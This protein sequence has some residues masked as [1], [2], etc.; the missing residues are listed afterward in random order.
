MFT[1]P[2]NSIQQQANN[3]SNYVE[4]IA[5]AF[6]PPPLPISAPPPAEESL[7]TESICQD[8][9]GAAGSTCVDL[10]NGDTLPH[11][12]DVKDIESFH[13]CEFVL[14][15]KSQSFEECATDVSVR[16]D[17]SCSYLDKSEKLL[18]IDV[19]SPA[20]CPLTE[21]D[22]N[23]PKKEASLPPVI[24]RSMIE[25]A[26]LVDDGEKL[27]TDVSTRYSSVAGRASS[28]NSILD[29]FDARHTQSALAGRLKGLNIPSC[30]AAMKR[31]SSTNSI[32]DD[33]F[34]K[35]GS[36]L[37]AS[38]PRRAPMNSNIDMTD[39]NSTKRPATSIFS[40]KICIDSKPE[41][42]SV[43][44]SIFSP[45][46]NIDTKTEQKTQMAS[47]FSPKIESDQKASNLSLTELPKDENYENAKKPPTYGSKPKS[48]S[49]PKEIEEKAN[50]L[51][52]DIAKSLQIL[53][54]IPL[55]PVPAARKSVI[56]KTTTL[57]YESSASSVQPQK[58]ICIAVLKLATNDDGLNE[59][60]KVEPAM[61]KPVRK[62]KE[63]TP[64][65]VL[66]NDEKKRKE[67]DETSVTSVLNG[68]SS[69]TETDTIADN[70][71]PRISPDVERTSPKR[72]KSATPVVSEKITVKMEK[73]TT[74]APADS[75]KNSTHLEELVDKI[76]L[77]NDVEP[78]SYA[79][80]IKEC[81]T[82]SKR[83]SIEEK[84]FVPPNKTFEQKVKSFENGSGNAKN[85]SQTDS[86]VPSFGKQQANKV[87]SVASRAKI[88]EQIASDHQ[89]SAKMIRNDLDAKKAKFQTKETPLD[90]KSS[91]KVEPTV[92]NKNYAVVK[93]TTATTDIHNKFNINGASNQISIKKLSTETI[94]VKMRVEDK[95]ALENETTVNEKVAASHLN[96][97][98]KQSQTPVVQS[99]EV[100][101]SSIVLKTEKFVETENNLFDN[102]SENKC[103]DNL[104]LND[105]KPSLN[106]A[107]FG[108]VEPICQ[109]ILND[110]EDNDEQ[111][112]INGNILTEARG[113]NLP[114][115]GKEDENKANG[116]N[117]ENNYEMI[118]VRLVREIDDEGSVGL[119]LTG[120][121]EG[122]ETEIMVIDLH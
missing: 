111:S 70:Q 24:C 16:D 117:Y 69:K 17:K 84:V 109:Q 7:A 63:D 100:R 80:L 18:E 37:P 122:H 120:N 12:E 11:L 94:S 58:Q 6:D 46:I 28:R 51:A 31:Y 1:E 97:P 104:N 23:P 82:V 39:Y 48:K 19:G 22:S 73:S 102:M 53:D 29:E 60:Y 59:D 55:K 92:K 67:I 33:M 91:K 50:E 81:K 108:D 99:D 79:M 119:I 86:Q 118:S 13:G 38:S 68:F 121:V 4:H 54:S 10:R 105:F 9:F 72:E 44:P 3:K 95:N 8:E 116:D 115:S 40:P 26:G 78:R 36:P 76:S 65:L 2:E 83:G 110:E 43:A 49:V 85:G 101:T 113:F 87:P 93:E 74:P 61:T 96:Q 106:M 75:E 35:L 52:E 25:P 57:L 14:T 42:K 98:S 56:E 30:P 32:H 112:K 45:K 71:R 62:S 41:R 107:R 114:D 20:A 64:D 66:D 15:R 77:A 21:F 89:Q 34:N 103:P 90:T 88:F 27:P 5:D 47:V